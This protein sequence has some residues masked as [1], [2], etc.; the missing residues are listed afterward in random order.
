MARNVE[1][2]E[3]EAVQKATA[4]FW[5]KGYNGASLRDLTDAMKINSSSLYNTIGDKHQLFLRCLKQY[6]DDKKQGFLELAESDP[7]P[8]KVLINFINDMAGTIIQGADACMVV[9]TAFEVGT[10]DKEIQVILKADNDF[11]RNFLSSLVKK[12][13]AKGEISKGHDPET[14]ADFLITTYI[15]WYESFILYKD[16]AMIRKMAQYLIKLISN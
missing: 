14:I 9:K 10:D 2:N 6:T 1:F 8:L 3:A 7:S 4:I 15:G 5:K 13:K 16:P 12:A 11:T